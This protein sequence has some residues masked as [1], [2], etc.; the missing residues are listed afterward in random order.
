MGECI[1]WWVGGWVDGRD[2]VKSLFE[3]LSFVE[4]P[5]PMG[6]CGWL[7]GWVGQ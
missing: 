3:D 7:G 6:G 2:Q 5:P 1:I 4:T